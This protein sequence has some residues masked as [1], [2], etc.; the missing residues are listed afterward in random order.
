MS[1]KKKLLK[2]YKELCETIIQ[3]QEEKVAMEVEL[4]K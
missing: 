4:G 2:E 3:L 1:D